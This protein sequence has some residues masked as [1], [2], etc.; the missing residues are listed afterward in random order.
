MNTINKTVKKLTTLAMC[1]A[2]VSS[3]GILTSCEDML[4]VS[5]DDKIYEN[6]N[7]TVYSYFGILTCL[8]DI[9]ERQV[10]LGELRGDLVSTTKYVTDTLYAISNFDDPQDGSCSLLNIRDYYNVINNCNLYISNADTSMVK[11][12][13]KYMVPEYAQVQIIRAWTYLQLVQNYGEVPFITEPIKSLDVI[14]DFKY[15]EN[16][17]NKDNLIDKILETGIL[18]F[19]DTKYPDYKQWDNG[20]VQ[21]SAQKAIIPL[22]L[23]LGDMYLL[24]GR[25]NYD[26][27]TAAQYYYDYLNKTASITTQQYCEATKSTN[28]NSDEEYSYTRTRSS[29]SEFWGEWADNYSS[30]KSNDCISVIPSSANR[31]FGTMLTRVAD[32]FGYTP[33][34]SQRTNTI[35]NEEGESE[36]SSSG[37]ITV[38]P[39]Y[40]SQTVPSNAFYTVNKSQNY[41]Y[42]DMTS[43]VVPL[44]MEYAS[45]DARYRFSV[46]EHSHEKESYTLCSKAA[47]GGAFYYTI[48]IYRKALVW[49]RL[50][51]AINRSGFP[52]MAFAI[53]KNGLCENNM[54]VPSV[55]YMIHPSTNEYG[56]TIF[57]EEGNIILQ[58][59]TI[60]YLALNSFGAMYYVDSLELKNFYLDFSDNTWNG[61]Y[62]IHARGCGYGSWGSQGNS[63]VRTNISG[64]GD[65]ICY[66]YSHLILAQGLR[67]EV[68]SEAISAVENLIVDELALELAFEGYRFTDLV[69]IANH[70]INAGENGTDWLAKKIASRDIRIN[71]YKD[72]NEGQFNTSLYEKL[73]DKSKWY[74]T[75]PEFKK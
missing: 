9:A 39:N 42:Y 62:G 22:R 10:L 66:D 2:M 20:A 36:S 19:I 5:N 45:G 59:D 30:N 1:A 6:A 74:L 13:I 18:E 24:R 54:P 31:E 16:L 38:T 56:D 25:D 14:D 57:T 32:I 52:E 49:L 47:K 41:I 63:N 3:L 17:V 27:R 21:I 11:S 55:K 46:E 34:S 37:N 12:N 4:T 35:E 8:Q 65:S 60:P 28:R 33:S 15:S 26:Y 69:R 43:T 70:K 23:V 40:K 67:P 44:R 7:D 48:P 51:E 75:I 72:I 64:Y 29:D 71:T 58:I 73:K 50:A 53:L 68:K 61:N